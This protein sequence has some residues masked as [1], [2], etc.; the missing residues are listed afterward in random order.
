MLTFIVFCFYSLVAFGLTCVVVA[1]MVKHEGP[2]QPLQVL[3]RI[4]ILFLTIGTVLDNARTAA[5]TLLDDGPGAFIWLNVGV[6]W[7]CIANHQVLASICVLIPAYFAIA[8]VEKNGGKKT[9]TRCMTFAALVITLGLFIFQTTKFL[10]VLPNP[11]RIKEPEERCQLDQSIT[12]EASRKWGGSLNAVFAYQFGMLF[13]GIYLVIQGVRKDGC[14]TRS[15]LDWRLLFLVINFLC[16][17]GQALVKS[18][19]PFY[20]CYGSNFWE[21]MTFA[22]A[23]FVDGLFSQTKREKSVQL[24]DPLLT[25]EDS[26]LPP[27]LMEEAP[28]V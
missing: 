2:R 13:Y 7:F 28:D 16:V 6:S 26:Y 24:Q 5:G 20:N 4:G 25:K 8:S 22:S 19:G 12:L 11:L 27:K 17:P 23:V 18:L 15:C 9:V 3:C 10:S 21:Q 1:R 14:C